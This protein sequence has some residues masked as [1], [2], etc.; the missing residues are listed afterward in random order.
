MQCS[1]GSRGA[2]PEAMAEEDAVVVAQS[3]QLRAGAMLSLAWVASP[4]VHAHASAADLATDAAVHRHGN[5]LLACLRFAS[6][7]VAC[8]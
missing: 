7:A 6:A 5:H 2:K 4:C 1:G 3:P 8:C